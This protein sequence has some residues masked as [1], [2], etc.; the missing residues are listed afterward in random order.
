MDGGKRNNMTD[1]TRVHKSAA[2]YQKAI[3]A[4]ILIEHPDA[5]CEKHHK[6]TAFRKMLEDR[7]LSNPSEMIKEPDIVIF[8]DINR[9]MRVIEV[10]YHCNDKDVRGS[11]D[12]KFE[13]ALYKHIYYN[14]IAK[15]NDYTA[16]Y[17]FIAN[18]RHDLPK[19]REA[20]L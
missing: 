7:G 12:E 18:N 1:Q 2:S 3:E 10:K 8:D 16:T 14:D 5:Y 13:T 15:T 9:I 6:P 19:I 11:V 17:E 20:L 4:E